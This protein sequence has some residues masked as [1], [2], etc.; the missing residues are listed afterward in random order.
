MAASASFPSLTGWEVHW[1]AAGFKF[2]SGLPYV[3]YVNDVEIC[4]LAEDLLRWSGR[5]LRKDIGVAGETSKRARKCIEERLCDQFFCDGSRAAARDRNGKAGDGENSAYRR[6]DNPE[7]TDKY[8][9]CYDRA[10]RRRLRACHA[11]AAT[12]IVMVLAK[13]AQSGTYQKK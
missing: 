5:S 4:L 6:S 1:C 11:V 3:N 12:G 8:E 13:G 2:L 9:I 10:G 7:R